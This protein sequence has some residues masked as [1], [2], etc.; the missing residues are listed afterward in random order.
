MSSSVK[1]ICTLRQGACC[2]EGEAGAPAAGG[3]GA[4]HLQYL[5]S[6]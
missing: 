5:S 3:G 6:H 4:A 2:I 1:V